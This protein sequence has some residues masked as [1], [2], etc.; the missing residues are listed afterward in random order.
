[1]LVFREAFDGFHVAL[2][3]IVAEGDTVAVRGTLSGTH[4][5][6]F[7]G[8]PPTGKRVSWQAMTFFR[9]TNGR[10][11]E[12]WSSHDPLGLLKEVGIIPERLEVPAV[13]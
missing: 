4:G 6:Y 5:G 1:M 8:V 11:M 12:R 2:E 3:Q 9:I 7:M 13:R 10:I